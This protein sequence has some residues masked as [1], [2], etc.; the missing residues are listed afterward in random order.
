MNVDDLIRKIFSKDMNLAEDQIEVEFLDT[1]VIRVTIDKKRVWTC[2]IGSDDCE[3]FFLSEVSP[4]V[5]VVDISNLDPEDCE[6]YTEPAK[7]GL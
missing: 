3:L 5:I 4:V 7:Y 6:E 1:E 2:Q